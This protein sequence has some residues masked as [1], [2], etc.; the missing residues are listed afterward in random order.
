MAFL[1]DGTK[2]FP[3]PMLTYHQSGPVTIISEQFHAGCISAVNHLNLLANYSSKIWLKSPRGQWS[4]ISSE[5][6]YFTPTHSL[7]LFSEMWY[8]VFLWCL[9]SS[10]FVHL[11][12][13]AI[14]FGRL[15]KHKIGRFIPLVFVVMGLV[16]PLTGGVVTSRYFNNFS[17]WCAGTELSRFN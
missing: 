6:S 1:P 10:I 11:I 3:E 12:A 14:A 9:F 13:A 15:R 16:S 5:N 8:Q 17:P 4:K 7:F 2:P